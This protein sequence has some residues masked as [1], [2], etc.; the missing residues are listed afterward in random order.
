MIAF[1]RHGSTVVDIPSVDG[2]TCQQRNH[3]SR[4]CA[5]TR[6][7]CHPNAGR[8]FASSTWGPCCSGSLLSMAVILHKRRNF[9]SALRMQVVSL[10]VLHS[11]PVLAFQSLIQLGPFAL[12]TMDCKLS[13]SPN[14]CGHQ[15]PGQAPWSAILHLGFSDNSV[16]THEL[17]MQEGKLVRPSHSSVG[18]NHHGQH[19]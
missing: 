7:S 19:T 12:W 15:D 13:P 8:L 17:Q 11:S 1:R 4:W 14:P 18:M 10:E 3:L 6:H 16:E 9:T 5:H 2:D